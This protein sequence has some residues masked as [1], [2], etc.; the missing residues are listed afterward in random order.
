MKAFTIVLG[1]F[2]TFAVSDVV[3]AAGDVP[4]CGNRRAVRC[5]DLIS[6]AIKDTDSTMLAFKQ[7]SN[8]RVCECQNDE[9]H[10]YVVAENDDHFVQIMRKCAKVAY[11]GMTCI[12]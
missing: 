10:L 11:R 3:S 9:D 6:D 8:E 2:A 12:Q 5:V 4:T 7:S 1:L